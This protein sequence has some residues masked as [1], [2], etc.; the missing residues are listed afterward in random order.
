GYGFLRSDASNYLPGPEDIY[1]SPSQIKRF[2]LRKGHVVSGQIRPPKE[3]ERF[4]ALLK[5]QAVN[6]CDPDEARD[7][8]L[9]DNLTPL[10][11]ERKIKLEREPKE[12]SMRILDLFTPIGMGQRGLIVAP[13]RTGKTIL[14]Q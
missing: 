3:N 9:F 10:Y 13:P 8:M 12:I 11:P 5:V 2:G 7:K 4:F 6:Y 1:V 14:L